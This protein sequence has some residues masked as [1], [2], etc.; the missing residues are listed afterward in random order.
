MSTRQAL[1]EQLVG[2][3]LPNFEPYNR[4]PKIETEIRLLVTNVLDRYD[5]LLDD[6]DK[7][8]GGEG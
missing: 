4:T 6:D 2:E 5:D 3:I 7:E 1:I 8:I